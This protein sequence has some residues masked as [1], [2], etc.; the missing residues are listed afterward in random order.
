MERNANDERR[1]GYFGECPR[2]AVCEL[3]FGS[4]RREQVEQLLA[5]GARWPANPAR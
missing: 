4:G 2:I 1:Q 5:A 3:L